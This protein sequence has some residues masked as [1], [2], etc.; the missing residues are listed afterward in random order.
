MSHAFDGEEHKNKAGVGENN[1]KFITIYPSLSSHADM[2]G[3][4]GTYIR[5]HRY[6]IQP[7]V[8]CI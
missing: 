8:T 3:A 2:I 1:F 6:L 7:G 4:N 5:R